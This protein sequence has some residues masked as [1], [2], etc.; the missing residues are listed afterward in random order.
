MMFLVI[1]SNFQA[2]LSHHATLPKQIQIQER[3]PQTISEILEL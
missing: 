3:I 1:H 2:V